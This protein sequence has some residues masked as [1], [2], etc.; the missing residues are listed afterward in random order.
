MFGKINRQHTYI[1]IYMYMLYIYIC[2]C[3]YKPFPTP[4]FRMLQCV[5]DKT[6]DPLTDF[7]RKPYC[8]PFGAD[9]AVDSGVFE[10]GQHA[11]VFH[12]Y[13]PAARFMVGFCK[14]I[15]GTVWI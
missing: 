4:E 7:K 6:G 3:T 12:V 13:L 14:S 9:S 10:L 15:Q 5:G 11:F 2:T 1:Y 8:K